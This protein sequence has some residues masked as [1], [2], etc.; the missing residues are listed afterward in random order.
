MI[1]LTHVIIALLSIVCTSVGFVRPTQNN[2]HASYVLA[3]LT[4]AT[5]TYMVLSESVGI[6]HACLSGVAYLSVVMAG[7]V[8]TRRKLAFM[9]SAQE[10]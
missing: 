5:G 6:L 1:I 9:Q 7:I 2:L 8:L 3:A 10:V 4:F